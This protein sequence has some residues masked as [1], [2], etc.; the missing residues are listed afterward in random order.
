MKAPDHALVLAYLTDVERAAAPL[1][2][3]RRGELLAD[4]REH[5]EVSLADA[6]T[7]DEAA[8]RA[9]LAQLGEPAAIAAA[10]LAE[11]PAVPPA[12]EPDR[13]RTRLTILVLACVGPAT[14]I[15]GPL[16]LVL[17]AG[18]GLYLLST[19]PRWTPRQ[20]LKGGA[21][22]LA[23]PLLLLLAGLAGAGRLGPTELLLLLGLNILLPLLGARLLWRKASTTRPLPAGV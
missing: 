23:L 3:A 5:I 20:K 10:A 19:S 14:L 9:V 11:A 16:A 12:P 13:F 17:A 6:D 7:R 2:P 18:A 4:L 8:V 22:T 1:D 21:L 15:G